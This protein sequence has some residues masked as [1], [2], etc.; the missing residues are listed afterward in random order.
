M[1]QSVA[2][3]LGKHHGLRGQPMYKFFTPVGCWEDTQYRQ[4]YV[5]GSVALQKDIENDQRKR[6]RRLASPAR[7]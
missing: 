2:Y 6:H 5:D 1:T 4:G 3:E 7:S